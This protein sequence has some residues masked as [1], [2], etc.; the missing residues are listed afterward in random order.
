[1]ALLDRY[2]AQEVALQGQILAPVLP[3]GRVAVRLPS[4]AIYT[5]QTGVYSGWGVFLLSGAE[6]IEWLREAEQWERLKYLGVLPALRCLLIYPATGNAWLA[7]P[8]NHSDAKQRGFPEFFQLRL[9]AVGQALD[10]V[11][12]RWD[13]KTAWWECLD[14]R[15]PEPWDAT[16]ARA[17]LADLKSPTLT[18]TPEQ[19]I[20]YSLLLEREREARISK[21]ERAMQA[22]LAHLGAKLTGFEPSGGGFIVRFLDGAERR[23]VRVDSALGVMSAGICLS[24]LDSDFDLASIV[25]VLRGR[26]DGYDDW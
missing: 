26:A 15:D 24:G 25:A 1:M 18:L 8:W 22:D 7:M 21:E 13:G 10:R 2:I 3:H 4:G 6:R 19:A 12:A 5:Y 9:V 11:V 16:D 23:E 14:Y 17:D 20:A